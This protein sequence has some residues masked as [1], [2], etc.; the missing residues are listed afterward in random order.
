[1]RLPHHHHTYRIHQFVP[2]EGTDGARERQQRILNSL[3][4]GLGSNNS[5]SRRHTTQ[6]ATA[7]GIDDF[8]NGFHAE[9]SSGSTS[10]SIDNGEI[11]MAAAAE[12]INNSGRHNIGELPLPVSFSFYHSGKGRNTY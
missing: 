11:Q 4:L 12:S 10:F 9:R 8:I 6:T 5:T 2:G 1:M 7:A 3:G